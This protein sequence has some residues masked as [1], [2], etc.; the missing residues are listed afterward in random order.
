MSSPVNP[1]NQG[2]PTSRG[3]PCSPVIPCLK[4]WTSSMMLKVDWSKINP[5]LTRVMKC[6][7]QI[8]NHPHQQRM[9][10][11]KKVSWAVT[12]R[13]PWTT[14]CPLSS[15]S[16]SELPVPRIIHQTNHL[17]NKVRT[18]SSPSLKKIPLMATAAMIQVDKKSRSPR[19]TF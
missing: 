13:S 15:L 5:T 6:H 10:W 16:V 3:G 8:R 2:I 14:V 11:T 18:G 7:N 19:R 12:Y 4:I 17:Y 9:K 1:S